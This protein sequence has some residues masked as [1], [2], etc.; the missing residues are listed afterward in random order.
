VAVDAVGNVYVA[1]SYN[2]RIQK[3]DSDGT[4]L[5][6]W[7]SPGSGDGEFVELGGVAVDAVGYVYVTDVHN[8]RI[9]K[10]DSDG[11]YKTQW[12]SWGS[13]DGEFKN[14]DGVAVDVSGNVYV[15]ENHR[16]QKFDSDGTYLTQWGS[17]GSGDGE[18]K[19]PDGVA[20]DS[21]GSVYVADSNNH[22]I[23]KF[24]YGGS[25]AGR[26][27]DASGASGL[28]NVIVR[29]FDNTGSWVR[30]AR[31]DSAGM[32]S[33]AC[34]FPGTHT[35]HTKNWSGYLDEL[36]DD[37]PCSDWDCDV[38][39]GTQIP[40]TQGETTPGIDFALAGQ[41]CAPPF[42]DVFFP[43]S[44]D[45][46]SFVDGCY[47]QINGITRPSARGCFKVAR[48]EWNWGDNTI[49]DSW[50]PAKHWYA[51]ADTPATVTVTAYD[52]EGSAATEIGT[53]GFPGCPP[54][55]LVLSGPR[56]TGTETFEACNSITARDFRILAPSGAVT[57]RAGSEMALGHG[58]L[59]EE[60]CEFTAL[61][62]KP[63]ACP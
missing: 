43:P 36:Y 33:V 26:V 63:L 27:T 4:Y 41:V 30:N 18:F 40:V 52:T 46:K 44:A 6:Q 35:A 54:D 11:T 12:G 22:R 42:L 53:V 5:T 51:S 19:Y 7:G 37:L 55:D 31:T 48:V 45:P 61:I 32:Y 28:P 9:Q 13:G 58:V 25:I 15:V 23:Q 59:V 39:I 34:V 47:V 2:D 60:G 57:F 17:W 8:H 16:I 56:I 24:S 38:T 20:V 62:E 14:P 3:F 21:S 50:F 29:V 49:R 10:F 1:D